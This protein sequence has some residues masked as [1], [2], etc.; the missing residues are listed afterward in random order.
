MSDIIG[1]EKIKRSIH[2]IRD[3]EK[4]FAEND[5]I[6]FAE[7]ILNNLFELSKMKNSYD[8]Q[9]D[10]KVIENDISKYQEYIFE[11]DYRL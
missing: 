10:R 1:N 3:L 2:K 6:Y 5:S 11:C 4:K 7:N 9:S 8:M